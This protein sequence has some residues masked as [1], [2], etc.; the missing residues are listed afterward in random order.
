[1]TLL[2]MVLLVRFG[3]LQVTPRAVVANTLL[4]QPLNVCS[5]YLPTLC[6]D[7]L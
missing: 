5:T 2:T 1:M 3:K 6:G 4:R 7:Q